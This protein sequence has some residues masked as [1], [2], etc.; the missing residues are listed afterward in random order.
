M[1]QHY[2]H[3]AKEQAEVKRA[4]YD[5]WIHKHTPEEI[6]AANYARARL[7][8]KLPGRWPRLADERLRATRITPYIRFSTERY[9][10]GDFKNIALADRSK[11]IGNEWKALSASEKQVRYV[12]PGDLL[13]DLANPLTQKYVDAFEAGKAAS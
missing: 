4:E 6:R 2:N 11:L 12:R 5:A 7:R 3:L 10:S 13:Y 9:A 1:P 8:G